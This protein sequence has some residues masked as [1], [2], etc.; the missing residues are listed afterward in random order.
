M[1]LG[2]RETLSDIAALAADYLGL[3]FTENGTSLYNIKES[4]KEN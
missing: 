1:N 4:N 2:E 3:D